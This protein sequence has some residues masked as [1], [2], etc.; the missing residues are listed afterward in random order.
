MIPTPPLDQ[1]HDR[2]AFAKLHAEPPRL[3][4]ETRDRLSAFDEAAFG[5]GSGPGSTSMTG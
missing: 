3:G 5:I 2:D 4:D 1:S